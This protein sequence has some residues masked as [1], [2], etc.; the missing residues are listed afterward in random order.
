MEP[1]TSWYASYLG[2]GNPDFGDTFSQI[3]T[4]TNH[5]TVPENDRLS[6]LAIRSIAQTAAFHFAAIEQGSSSL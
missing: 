3:V 6:G 5:P 4:I 1:G 2:A